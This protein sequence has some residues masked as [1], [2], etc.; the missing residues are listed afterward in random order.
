MAAQR[1]AA[2]LLSSCLLAL[3]TGDDVTAQWHAS[4][5]GL[6][7][8]GSIARPGDCVPLELLSLQDVAGPIAARVAYRFTESVDTLDENGMVTRTTRPVTR[9]L[10]P[11][12]TLDGLAPLQRLPLDD[13]LCFGE[14]SPS[15]VYV[16]E[17]VLR[18]SSSSA[19]YA[20]LRTCVVFRAPSPESPADPA[21]PMATAGCPLVIR[22][23]RRMEADGLL[24]L[25]GDFPESGMYKAALVRDDRI[26]AVLEGGV[27]RSGPHELIVV[28]PDTPQADAGDIDLVVL[29]ATTGWS[30]TLARVAVPRRN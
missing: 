10:P 9:E 14:G 11:G 26:D 1:L 4:V 25:D 17:T 19:P 15:G 6:R 12:P 23:V 22:G 7:T 24:S 5:L 28:L 27:Y 16:I 3:A 20:T 30:A 29:D 21:Q 18:P 2:G 13:S 8:G